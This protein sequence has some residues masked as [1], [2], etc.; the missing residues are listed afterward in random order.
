MKIRINVCPGNTRQ[1]S[2][3]RRRM[4]FSSFYYGWGYTITWP[5]S[6]HLVN[7]RSSTGISSPPF[8]I[9][10]SHTQRNQFTRYTKRIGGAGTSSTTPHTAGPR[11][12]AFASNGGEEQ[13]YAERE[14]QLPVS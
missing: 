4:A 2:P 7:P 13:V 14:K 11:Q 1:E 9:V 8:H 12:Q 5:V 10:L 6:S 3:A